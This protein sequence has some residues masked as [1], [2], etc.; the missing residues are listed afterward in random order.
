M[1][2]IV[3][4]F[5]DWR[6][7]RKEGFRTRDAHFIEAFMSNPEVKTLIINR[8]TS[9]LEILLKKKK[10]HIEGD[11]IY[12]KNQFCLYQ[13]N[14]NTFLIDYISNDFIG[15]VLR[16]FKWFIDKYEE[17]SFIK[18]I[19]ESLVKIDFNEYNVLS[20]NIF[21]YK[22]VNNFSFK[23][24]MFD[25]WDNF[26]KFKVYSD[27][28]LLI[29][30]GYKS[31][32]EECDF[33]ITN[34]NDNVSF[35]KENF[36][37]PSIKLIK[38]GLDVQ[39]FAFS[40]NDSVPIDLQDLPKPV[41][42]FGGKIT[43]LLDIE[44]I[45]QVLD[46]NPQASFVFVGQILDKEIFNNIKKTKNFYYL[47]DIHYDNYVNFVKNFDVCIVPYVTDEASKSG[48]NSIK[49]YEYLATGKKVVGTRGNG[50][51]D[52]EEHLYI[53]EDSEQFTKE[54]KEYKTNIKAP[55]NLND[56]NW[57]NKALEILK[58]LE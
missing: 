40:K 47:G 50:L 39:R 52:L 54:I 1:N 20:Q 56:H 43:H 29:E 41:V 15:Q 21:A 37:V 18:F 58:M 27:I 13:I 3:I 24:L 2:V 4:P 17:K 28:K 7:I 11:V 31:Y 44:L 5:H 9:F 49:M 33:W 57:E 32:S 36:K 48:A 16:K 22:L 30:E 25:G 34:S 51:E 26:L 46:K 42:G 12:K 23:K 45:N 38:N 8:P 6:K 35:F 19:N 10:I 14:T 55:I 53:V